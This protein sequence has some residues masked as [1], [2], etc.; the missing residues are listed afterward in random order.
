[1]PHAMHMHIFTSAGKRHETAKIPI[2]KFFCPPSCTD[3]TLESTLEHAF[4][5]PAHARLLCLRHLH[6][7]KVTTVGNKGAMEL[8]RK[9]FIRGGG[10]GGDDKYA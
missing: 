8:E 6:E 5:W 9:Q 1:M 10:G 4:V 2:L 3:E 7:A